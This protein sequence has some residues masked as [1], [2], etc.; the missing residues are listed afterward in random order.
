MVEL[1]PPDLPESEEWNRLFHYRM[2]HLIENGKELNKMKNIKKI[3]AV[4]L[5]MT[6][7]ASTSVMAN[8]A[9]YASGTASLEGVSLNAAAGDQLTVV[10]VPKDAESINSGNIYYINQGAFGKEFEDILAAM[11]VK[12]GYEEDYEEYE[13]RIGGVKE[14][15][16]YTVKKF[17]FEK[18]ATGYK[19]TG[20]VADTY[21]TVTLGE[22]TVEVADDGSFSFAEVANGV[23]ELMIKAPGAFNR[24]VSATVNNADLAVSTADNQLSLVYGATVE[25]AET[26]GF[27]DYMKILTNYGTATTDETIMCDFDRDGNI[28]F[29]DYM[30]VLTNYGLKISDAY[31]E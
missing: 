31:T 30:K 12:D 14:D 5:S 4:L 7:I 9:K 26:I 25:D 23:Y 27:A 3:V 15:G 10:I 24:K 8:E 28:G 16:S 21:A 13:V 22:K 19:I 6:A 2:A 17:Y 29:S 18:V 1:I 11:K 20:Y